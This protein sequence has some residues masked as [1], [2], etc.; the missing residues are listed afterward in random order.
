MKRGILPVIVLLAMVTLALGMGRK[1]V[2]VKKQTAPDSS[3]VEQGI[4]GKVEIWQGN[5]MPVTDPKR[6][7]SQILPGAGRR[8]RVYQPVKEST[9]NG[10]ARRDSVATPLV[11]ETVA[12]STGHFFLK[13][14]PGEYS[15]F[16]EENG[17]WYANG[18]NDQ[19]VQGSVK[20]EPGKVT[21]VTLK[22][23]N[24]ATF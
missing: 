4:R 20:V 21:D 18:W 10:A 8:V 17:G 2:R 11:A 5:F 15:V 22:I 7:Q 19:G 9:A 12:D 6:S 14:A 16:V 3:A 13:V 1:E 24:K 23:T